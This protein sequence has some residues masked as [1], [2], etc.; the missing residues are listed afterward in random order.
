[1]N[2]RRFTLRQGNAKTMYFRLRGQ[3]QKPQQL[4]PGSLVTLTMWRESSLP[5]KV[6]NAAPCVVLDDGSDA[7]KGRGS[8]LFTA[9]QSVAL[10]A[11]VYEIRFD[12][13][14]G[15]AVPL[16]F[17]DDDGRIDP[18]RKLLVTVTEQV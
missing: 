9:V 8:Y 5:A 1:M 13:L 16:T 12:A 7:Q 4:G 15:G 2:L 11:G 10:P 6:I 18:D 3:D 17:P 14:I